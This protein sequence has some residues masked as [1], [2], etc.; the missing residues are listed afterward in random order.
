MVAHKFDPKK[1]DRL[2]RPDRLGDVTAEEVLSDAGLAVGMT[3]ADIGSGP[4]FFTVPAAAI[5]GEGGRVYAVELQQEMLDEMEKR[6]VPENVT[7]IKCD[8]SSFPI[9]DGSVGFALAAFVLHEAADLDAFLGECWRILRP[10]GTLLVIDWEKQEEESGPP[11]DERLSLNDARAAL[12]RAALCVTGG[13]MIN[14]SH[15]KL[16]GGKATAGG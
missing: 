11:K 9:A 2:L 14:G 7:P 8:E 5:V 12:A 1:I 10:G 3:F 13:E 6:G 16:I 4:G 15:Y